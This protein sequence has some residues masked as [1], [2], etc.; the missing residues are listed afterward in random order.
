V[1]EAVENLRAYNKWFREQV[2]NGLDQIERG[3][4]LDGDEVRARLDRVFRR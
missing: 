1:R 4:I 3:E 2:R